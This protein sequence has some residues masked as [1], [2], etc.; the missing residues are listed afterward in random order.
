MAV[1]ETVHIW[2][3]LPETAAERENVQ[4]LKSKYDPYWKKGIMLADVEQTWT[5]CATHIPNSCTKP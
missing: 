1:S 2:I 5:V 4:T 3:K